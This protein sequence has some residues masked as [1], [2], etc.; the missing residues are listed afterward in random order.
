MAAAMASGR[1]SIGFEID[2]ALQDEIFAIKENIVRFSNEY[3]QERIE[4]HIEYVKNRIK[5]KQPINHT[6]KIYRF[7]VMTAQEKQIMLNNLVELNQTDENTFQ[8]TY[9]DKPQEIFQKPT[10]RNQWRIGWRKNLN[11]IPA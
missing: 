7:P 10:D 6:N 2:M 11:P 3:I 1:N 5:K 9:S 4:K 8:V